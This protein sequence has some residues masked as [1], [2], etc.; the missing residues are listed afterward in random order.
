MLERF[1]RLLSNQ[2][3]LASVEKVIVDC[4]AEFEEVGG[5]SRGADSAPVV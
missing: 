5:A 2:L 1:R 3:W 4:D